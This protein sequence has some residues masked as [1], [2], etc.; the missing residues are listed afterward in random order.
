[1]SF[2]MREN[3]VVLEKTVLV[4]RTERCACSEVASACCGES[5]L[6]N[7]VNTLEYDPGL[8][9]N[10]GMCAIVCPHAVFVAGNGALG[11]VAQLVGWEACMECGACQLNCPTGAIRVD[12][13]VGCAAAM[14]AA[15]LTGKEPTCGPETGES[16]CCS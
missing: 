7:D 11:G 10:C 13:G 3:T 8:C 5:V 15:A 14:I 9:I 2:D 12:S 16:C 6:R 4:E 1:M